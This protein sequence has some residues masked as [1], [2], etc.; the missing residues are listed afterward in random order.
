MILYQEVEK[1]HILM[2]QL[3]KKLNHQ[4]ILLIENNQSIYL[5]LLFLEVKYGLKDSI[6]INMGGIEVEFQLLGEQGEENH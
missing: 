1:Y 3:L 5:F 4:A 6:W 2:I